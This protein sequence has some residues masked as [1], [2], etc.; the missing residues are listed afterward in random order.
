MKKL[1]GVLMMLLLAV[2]SV[3]ATHVAP[4]PPVCPEGSYQANG[5][6]AAWANSVVS[7]QGTVDD[8]DEALG[9]DDNVWATVHDGSPDPYLVLD[10]GAGEEVWDWIS[11]DLTIYGDSSDETAYVY[12]SNDLSTWYY[13]GSVNSDETADVELPNDFTSYR[14][15]KIRNPNS[16]KYVEVDAVKGYCISNPNE[17]NDVPEFTT[18]G[19]GLILLGAGAFVAKKRK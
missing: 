19:A 8:E 1:T 3:S 5:D 2:V 4:P 9:P 12:V 7:T 17:Q 14:Y 6:S 16:N 13:A 18:I 11:F 15:V 10:M